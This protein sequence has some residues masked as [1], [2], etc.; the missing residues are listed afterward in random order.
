MLI[1]Y[2]FQLVGSLSVA[3]SAIYNDS[4]CSD[5]YMIGWSVSTTR[6]S[7][8]NGSVVVFD[9]IPSIC[10][11]KIVSWEFSPATIHG[12]IQLLVLR[13]APT[14]G[15][16]FVTGKHKINTFKGNGLKHRV[17]LDYTE[18]LTIRYGDFIGFSS[19][20]NDVLFE[21]SDGDSKTLCYTNPSF[22]ID[23][24]SIVT[25]SETFLRSYSMAVQILTVSSFG[26]HEDN[27][28]GREMNVNP[29]TFDYATDDFIECRDICA[30][31]SNSY[32]AIRSGINACLCGN[33]LTTNQTDMDFCTG[34]YSTMSHDQSNQKLHNIIFSNNNILSNFNISCYTAI[35][36]GI[37]AC[38]CGNQ[39][40]TN[41]IDMD[42]C[43]GIYSTMSHD[44][45]NQKLHNIIFSNNNILSNFNISWYPEL[46]TYGVSIKML[47]GDAPY[48]ITASVEP[49]HQVSSYRFNFGDERTILGD[50][51]IQEHVFLTPGI[52]S[53]TF[54]VS[55]KLNK[56][57]VSKHIIT[58]VY[59]VLDTTI[60]CVATVGR[61][62]CMLSYMVGSEN[63]VTVTFSDGNV[64][65]FQT[66]TDI[67]S[68]G[69]NY[70]VPKT[71]SQSHT[72]KAYYIKLNDPIKVD[73]RLMGFEIYNKVKGRIVLKLYRPIDSY[74]YRFCF[75]SYSYIP[76][77]D[78]CEK[79][80]SVWKK[81]CSGSYSFRKRQC[82][83]STT[84]DVFFTSPPKINL[85]LVKQF[86]FD[87]VLE[88]PQY[89][90]VIEE[91][92]VQKGDLICYK[93]ITGNGVIEE[94]M[95]SKFTEYMT[96]DAN[97]KFI[98][99]SNLVP[100]NKPNHVF[101]AI[102]N[103]RSR[104][105]I[106]HVCDV[107]INDYDSLCSFNV[108]IGGMNKNV[109]IIR[110]IDP[111]IH[112][113]HISSIKN[114]SDV[115]TTVTI[116]Q[117]ESVNL[118][119]PPSSIVHNESLTVDGLVLTNVIGLNEGRCRSKLGLEFQSKFSDTQFETSTT[120]R[121]SFP[122]FGRLNNVDGGWIPANTENQWIQV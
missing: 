33:Q 35:R 99:A 11:G 18:S 89:L 88:G 105:L 112:D 9:A 83:N 42:F 73:G 93:Y 15:T 1:L 102:V 7:S 72:G 28:F 115:T 86:P 107:D 80:R 75:S 84:S 56:S 108:L 120:E 81:I 3:E 100:S 87:N 17:S 20:N 78:S 118:T 74:G 26:C 12:M 94:E 29:G 57:L 77:E 103:R 27:I 70:L 10:F 110:V 36:S 109:S 59:D 63:D 114:G 6:T 66:N 64:T 19:V 82:I 14:N 79:Q 90:K 98:D 41:Q 60:D 121:N 53:T 96:N 104:A 2:L 40:T 111:P 22:G 54:E 16:F 44:E 106:S 91:I 51:G 69:S 52:R 85:K 13:R 113:V 47:Q 38:L 4:A 45:S 8:E 68:Y 76:V 37:N 67:V 23:K 43:T 97:L 39:L 95:T 58:V 71:N 21:N 34:I 55:D 49:S 101:R 122:Y 61:Y 119:L 50:V 32:T 25:C 92:S 46:D 5:S 65:Y 116:G 62:D 30:R 24:G 48:T 117:T 31:N